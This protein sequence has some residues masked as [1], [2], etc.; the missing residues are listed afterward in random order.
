MSRTL[1]R[2]LRENQ[3]RREVCQDADARY[4]AAIRAA[5]EA[6]HTLDEIGQTV[7]T[8]K[9][10]VWNLLYYRKERA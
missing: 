10:A 9:Q 1:Q 8:S 3:R 2:V 4:I 7:G 6:G 5:R